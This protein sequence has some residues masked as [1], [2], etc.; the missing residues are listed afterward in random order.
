MDIKHCPKCGKELPVEAN[1]CPYCMTK[2]IAEDGT[3]ILVS[4]KVNR[5]KLYIIVAIMLVIVVFAIIALMIIS[6][7]RKDKVENY[8]QYLGVWIDE[9]H[10]DTSDITKSGG[11]KI[12]ICKVLDDEIIFNIESY[13]SSVA[14]EKR[15][16]LEYIRVQLIDG[17]GTFSFSDD[18]FENSGTGKIELSD[19]KIYAR[20]ELD[21]SYTGGQW[22]LSMDADFVHTEM[23]ELGQAIDIDGCIAPYSLQKVKFGNRTDIEKYGDFISYIYENS[24]TVDLED[25]FV[26]GEYYIASVWIDYN[27]LKSDYKYCYK[28]IDN[29]CTKEDVDRIFEEENIIEEDI[30]RS[31]D[32]YQYSNSEESIIVQIYFDSEGYVDGIEYSAW[33]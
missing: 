17:K 20:I 4:K 30:Y 15:A 16:Y 23:Y 3:E 9:E 13:A 28:G 29:S 14:Y 8:T 32:Y 5:K 2:L 21:N 7:G 31:E 22:D 10:K 19:G 12:E 24:I 1:F 6:S 26:P 18:G 11:K 33:Y 25:F 27:S